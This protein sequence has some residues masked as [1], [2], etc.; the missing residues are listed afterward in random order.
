MSRL[1]QQLPYLQLECALQ[2]LRS[3]L[4]S[5]CVESVLNVLRGLLQLFDLQRQ[6]LSFVPK[7]LLPQLDQQLSTVLI[8]PQLLRLHN[9]SGLCTVQYWLLR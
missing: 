6:S 1:Q 5:H 7:R 8:D 3:G 2:L 9:F 4:L